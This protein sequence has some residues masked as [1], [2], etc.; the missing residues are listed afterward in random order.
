LVYLFYSVDSLNHY[1]SS[2]SV[3]SQY[4]IVDL[5]Q[6]SRDFI[7]HFLKVMT[8]TEKDLM[9]IIFDIHVQDDFLNIS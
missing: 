9:G 1:F 8:R 4:S 3:Q 7:G 6:E 5:I 2:A